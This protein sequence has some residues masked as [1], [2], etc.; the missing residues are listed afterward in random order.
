MRDSHQPILTTVNSVIA[1]LGGDTDVMARHRASAPSVCNWRRTRKFPAK[2]YKLMIDDLA[3]RG[4]AP[5]PSR[6]WGQRDGGHRKP[7]RKKTRR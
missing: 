2:E 6:L 5:P 4:F 1:A 3:Q 7:A